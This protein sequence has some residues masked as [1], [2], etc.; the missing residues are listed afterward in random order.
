M[1]SI[2]VY[3]RKL[4]GQSLINLIVRSRQPGRHVGKLAPCSLELISRISNHSAVFFSHNKPA[5][6]TFSH[7]TPAKRTGRGL[8]ISTRG[9]AARAGQLDRWTWPC[10]VCK[11]K[12][13][14]FLDSPSHRIFRHMYEALNIDKKIKLIT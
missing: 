5:N 9:Q 4:N 10:L 3:C 13:Q 11:K 12:L 2:D 8:A 7:N 6:G 1:E 14:N